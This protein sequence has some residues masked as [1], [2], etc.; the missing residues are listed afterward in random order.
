MQDVVDDGDT[1]TVTVGSGSYD[2]DVVA[3]NAALG[4]LLEN[5]DAV[6]AHVADLADAGDLAAGD[7]DSST[8]P[9]VT[10]GP[11]GDALLAS[12]AGDDDVVDAPAA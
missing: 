6:R 9:S 11:V 10:C 1:V 5:I 7:A 8:V 4:D 2:F 12:V 3:G